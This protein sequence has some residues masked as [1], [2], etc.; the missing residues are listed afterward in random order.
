MR[1]LVLQ[2][3]NRK[4]RPSFRYESSN[5]TVDALIDTGAE[6][7][8]WCRGE[9]RFK[10]AY[11]DAVKQDWES[12]IRGF[13]KDA[14]KG[15]VYIIPQFILTDGNEKYVVENLQLVVCKHPHIGY[16]FV[17]S[18][19]M[20]AKTDTFIHRINNKYVEIMYE[21]G[22]YQ[23]AAKRAGGAFS[24]VVFSQENSE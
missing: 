24:I 14:E 8:V 9:R 7:P 20:F 3:F 15:A 16:D 1:T 10:R 23:C 2:L 22:R 5:V 18:D 21:K 11:P 13:G 17:M 6:T 4:N 19:T 12:E